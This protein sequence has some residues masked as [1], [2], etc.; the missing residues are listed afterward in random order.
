MR[1][2]RCCK[3]RTTT[4]VYRE[5]F[6]KKGDVNRVVCPGGGKGEAEMEKEKKKNS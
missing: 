3:S 4:R 6:N 1:K 5:C 2:L